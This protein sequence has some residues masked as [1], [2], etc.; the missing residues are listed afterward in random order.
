MK[1]CLRYRNCCFYSIGDCVCWVSFV[2]YEYGHW[3]ASGALLQ[4]SGLREADAANALEWYA[5]AWTMLCNLR[6]RS[7]LSQV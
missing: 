2:R 5:W 6:N 3:T 4:P 1:W 7:A